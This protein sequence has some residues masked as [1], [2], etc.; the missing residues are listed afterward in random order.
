MGHTEARYGGT[1]GTSPPATWPALTSHW[2]IDHQSPFGRR[3][4]SAQ[5][6]DLT[7]LVKAGNALVEPTIRGEAG[8]HHRTRQ[9]Y[10]SGIANERFDG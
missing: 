6:D 10:E 8:L 2:G 9:Y 1:D 3:L 7:A 4:Q 5:T